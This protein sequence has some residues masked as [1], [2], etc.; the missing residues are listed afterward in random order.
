MLNL[1]IH[2]AKY[3]PDASAYD[4]GKRTNSITN[5]PPPSL[6]ELPHKNKSYSHQTIT[7]LNKVVTTT[8]ITDTHSSLEYCKLTKPKYKLLKRI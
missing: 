1:L 5:T 6:P 7:T 4:S 2:N 3:F 8:D